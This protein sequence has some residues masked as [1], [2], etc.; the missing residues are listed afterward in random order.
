MDNLK[1]IT[2]SVLIILMVVQGFAHPNMS[3]KSRKQLSYRNFALQGPRM[4]LGLGLGIANAFTDLAAS[5]ARSQPAVTDI[6]ARGLLPALS[7]YLRY[8][9][10]NI[11]A[12]KG[13]FN[14][15]QLKANDAWSSDLE[16]VNRGK[17]F[18][19]TIYEGSITGELHL[20]RDYSHPK[21]DINS[22][23]I[24]P[25]LF[26][27]LGLFYHQPDVQGEPI[28][29][30]DEAMNTPDLYSNWQLSVPMGMGVHWNMSSRWKMG[31][32]VNFRYTFFDYLDG[33]TRPY[34]TRNDFYF[35]T[36]FNIG[37]VFMKKER[38]T[39]KNVRKH[40]FGPRIE[41]R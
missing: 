37:Y 13:S 2:I 7:L 29:D 8:D 35:T 12:I 41:N 27:G 34:S 11:F 38:K 17:A 9:S 19:N 4:E 30:F 36:N 20:P 31:W 6:Y 5:N 32:E 3:K 15:C 23:Q 14:T 39:N 33:V 18:T 26:V 16:V 21:R 24:D 28:D 22:N 25:Y 40:V 1:T 10:G